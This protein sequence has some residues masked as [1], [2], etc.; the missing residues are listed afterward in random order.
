MIKALK[1]NLVQKGRGVWGRGLIS[2]NLFFLEEGFR[3]GEPKNAK[4]NQNDVFDDT[5]IKCPS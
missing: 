5:P 4:K 1:N 2:G 3:G